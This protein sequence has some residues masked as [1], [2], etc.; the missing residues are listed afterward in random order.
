[1]KRRQLIAAAL[2][3]AIVPAC[4]EAEEKSAGKPYPLETCIISGEELGSM[5]KPFVFDYKGQEVKLCCKAC[6]SKFDNDADTHLKKIQEGG[7]K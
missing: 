5:G 2:L 6:K 7:R 3:A 4:T 1:M